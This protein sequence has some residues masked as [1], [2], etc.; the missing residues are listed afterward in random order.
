MVLVKRRS[1][2]VSVSNGSSTTRLS[3]PATSSIAFGNGYI[4]TN[5]NIETVSS[6]GKNSPGKR[7]DFFPKMPQ[8]VYNILGTILLLASI[9]ALMTSKNSWRD[10]KSSLFGNLDHMDQVGLTTRYKSRI[11]K[12]I[13]NGV[14]N[15]SHHGP[16][17]TWL[18]K[19]EIKL[20]GNVETLKDFIQEESRQEA[21]K[22]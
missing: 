15:I 17:N 20:N 1:S 4:S 22:K 11:T 8:L 14:E 10:H 9:A 5:N 3:R 13:N 12:E 2:S 16:I 7:K 19:R 6:F 21:I 18:E